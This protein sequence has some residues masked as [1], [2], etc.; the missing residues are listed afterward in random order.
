MTI[1]LM[2]ID[3]YSIN[4]YS[5]LFYW[6]LLVA[7]ILMPIDDNALPNFLI[8]SSVS[9]KWKQQKNKELKHVPWFTTLWGKRACWSSG[10]GLGRMITLV[11]ICDFATNEF[12]TSCDYLTFTTTVAYIYNYCLHLKPLATTLRLTYD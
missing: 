6:W 7:I 10:M 2:S 12:T 1:L 9:L 4:V 11:E 3:D 8:N 5:W